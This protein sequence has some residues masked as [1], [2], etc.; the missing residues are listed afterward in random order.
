MGVK[1]SSRDC[2][3]HSP[4]GDPS[5][6]LQPQAGDNRSVA[7]LTR[8]QSPHVACTQHVS[9]RDVHICDAYFAS[10]MWPEGPQLPLTLGSH[11]W[12]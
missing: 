5:G 7:L 12:L 10:F 8:S 4:E 2:S 1:T 11:L 3:S 9:G 6:T